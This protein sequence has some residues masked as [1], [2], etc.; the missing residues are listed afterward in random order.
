MVERNIMRYYL[1]LEAFLGTQAVSAS[2]RW[3]ARLNAVYDLMERYPLQLHDLERAE[4]FDAKRR[5]REN[6][7]RLQQQLIGPAL[8]PQNP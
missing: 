2:Q 8:H 5:E 6:Q 7:L 3:E 4:Y 1:A